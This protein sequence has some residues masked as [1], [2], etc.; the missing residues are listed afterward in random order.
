M[1]I[2][3]TINRKITILKS[4]GTQEDFDI[5]KL[6]AAVRKA[7]G[8]SEFADTVIG[9]VCN[10]VVKVIEKDSATDTIST[11]FINALV[12]GHLL[13]NYEK[14]K[15][16]RYKVILDKYITNKRRKQDEL[17]QKISHM[18]DVILGA[19]SMREL[20]KFSF[21]QTQVAAA[22]YLLRDVKTGEIIETIPQWIH[23]VASHVVLGSVMY[24]EAIYSKEP[25]KRKLQRKLDKYSIGPFQL[26]IINRK[27]HELYDHMKYDLNG[28]K[29]IIGNELMEKYQ[30]LYQT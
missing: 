9:D 22:R 25:V 5:S 13:S 19:G 6:E 16:K 1:S 14:M 27:H 8:H 15:D 7:A 26:D 17:M 24:D 29:Y 23:R 3:T 18:K 21:N 30:S 4:F 20:K 10:Y 11:A 28:T 2:I 12:E